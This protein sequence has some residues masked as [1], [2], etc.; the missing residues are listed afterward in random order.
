MTPEQIVRKDINLP[1][2]KHKHGYTRREILDI[3][4]SYKIHWKTFDKKLG[5]NTYAFD[6]NGEVLTYGVDIA[7]A[8]RCCI[9]KREKHFCEWD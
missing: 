2:S 6:E 3:I 9:E 8:I 4:R 7:T 5:T 1:R